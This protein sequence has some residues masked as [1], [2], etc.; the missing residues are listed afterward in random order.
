MS[1]AFDT[2]SYAV[3]GLG[4]WGTTVA[5]LIARAGHDVVAWARDEAQVDELTR[6][7]RNSKYTGEFILSEKLYAT[8][9]LEQ[10][11]KGRRLILFCIPSQG[12]RDVLGQMAPMVDG[13]QILVHCV[14]GLEQGSFKRISEIIREETM[15]R[16]LG[17]LCGPNIAPE[18]LKGAPAASVVASRYEIVTEVTKDA[19][20]FSRFMIYESTDVV[21][22]ELA[23]AL[24]NILAI[25]AGMVSELNFGVNTFAF[26]LTRGLA[27]IQ[28]LGM[29]LG[30]ERETFQ[31]L[32]GM[33]DVIATCSSPLSRNH[34][35]GR[36]LA[37]GEKL[38]EIVQSLGMVAEG[39]KTTKAAW[40]LAQVYKVE[41]PI[42]E[43]M[44]RIIE[45]QWTIQEAVSEL[46]QREGRS[47]AQ[48]SQKLLDG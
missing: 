8:T 43:A 25:A 26:L 33:G 1:S 36:R 12:A 4:N 32:A 22:L 9:D 15:V 18:I 23:G 29:H 44:Y 35:V 45:G 5:E 41:M 21:G 27:E 46:M 24:K 6:E 7:H 37:R 19:F 17:V 28:R 42:T 48:A 40:D 2:A 30:A 3:I 38:D 11:V 31:G 10:A 14:K 16:K 39:V 34:Q 13:S 47:E 20:R